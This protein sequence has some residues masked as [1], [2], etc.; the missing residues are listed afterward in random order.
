MESVTEREDITIARDGHVLAAWHYPTVVD[1]SDRCRRSC[2]C[3]HS[4][5]R[6]GIHPRLRTR[7][8]RAGLRASGIHTVVFDYSG[9]GDSEGAARRGERRLPAARLRMR[10]HRDARPRR[11]PK[12]V[13]PGHVLRRW[14]RRR[15]GGA[16]VRSL[17]SSRS[18]PNLDN[19]ATALFLVQTSPCMEPGW[20]P[21]CCAT[22]SVRCASASAFYVRAMGP[23]G[24][25]S[26]YPPTT[27]GPGSSTWPVRPGNNRIGLRRLPT[28]AG[29]PCR[30]LPRPASRVAFSSSRA[31]SATHSGRAD[32]GRRWEAG[33]KADLYRVQAG[34]FDDV[35]VEPFLAPPWL[36]RPS[37]SSAIAC[38]RPGAV[39]AE[40]VTCRRGDAAAVLVDVQRHPNGGKARCG[41]W[42]RSQTRQPDPIGVTRACGPISNPSGR[43]RVRRAAAHSPAR[44]RTSCPAVRTGR[45]VA[46]PCARPGSYSLTVG[47]LRDLAED[48]ARR[49]E[50][51]V[52]VP[53]RA[54][55]A[56]G[57]EV[58]TG[59]GLPLGH[60]AGT[61]DAHERPR[62][63]AQIWALQRREAMTDRLVG[64]RMNADSRSMS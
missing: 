12:H 20:S 64:D 7:Q 58:K 42:M 23:E 48:L 51:L 19:L 50:R 56:A 41:H 24:S 33:D 1:R 4:R 53:Q 55:A 29:L 30:L 43:R 15:R 49:C 61:V 38:A 16:T 21:A 59:R 8:L 25:G 47:H 26:A 54:G 52:H 37:S 13:A 11:R 36:R 6:F 60:V 22:A 57:G 27:S 18:A 45:P 32:A 62:D 28:A 63:A 44:W 35:Y 17:R 40:S 9:F 39:A 34:H 3:G 2:A 31:N 46:R 5:P 14:H 10:D